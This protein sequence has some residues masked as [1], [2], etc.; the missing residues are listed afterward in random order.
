MHITLENIY[1]HL[2]SFFCMVVYVYML[3]YMQIYAYIGA[4]WLVFGP[5]LHQ[6]RL[7]PIKDSEKR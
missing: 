6:G 7:D 4:F 1:M 3:I 5:V 2:F